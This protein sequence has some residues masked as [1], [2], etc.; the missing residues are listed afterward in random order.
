VPETG[1]RK[2]SAP[3]FLAVIQFGSPLVGSAGSTLRD[4]L[5]LVSSQEKKAST[6]RLS[7]GTQISS[8]SKPS[9]SASMFSFT[10]VLSM[11]FVV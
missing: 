9:T 4:F 2:T 5:M 1:T 8:P 11:I 6:R 3:T 10:D 7:V